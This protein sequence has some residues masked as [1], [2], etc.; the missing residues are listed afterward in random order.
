M[1]DATSGERTRAI[2]LSIVIDAPVEVVWEAISSAEELV[3]WFPLE[4]ELEP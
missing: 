4:A 3:R 2:D 1:A